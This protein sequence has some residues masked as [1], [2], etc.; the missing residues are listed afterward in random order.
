MVKPWRAPLVAHLDVAPHDSAGGWSEFAECARDVSDA[1]TRRLGADGVDDEVDIAWGPI[2]HIRDPLDRAWRG[3]KPPVLI[4]DADPRIRLI[5]GH[6]SAGDV[7]PLR[8]LGETVGLRPGGPSLGPTPRMRGRPGPEDLDL[9]WGLA[10]Q[11]SLL[12]LR[13]LSARRPRR[14]AKATRPPQQLPGA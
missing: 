5:G 12:V 8:A 4:V 11:R 9:L 13:A 7:H 6:P 1:D 14:T 2:V 10:C 3:G